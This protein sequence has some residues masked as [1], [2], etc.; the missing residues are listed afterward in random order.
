MAMVAPA[1]NALA[2][3]MAMAKVPVKVPDLALA[4]AA[5]TAAVLVARNAATVQV[6]PGKWTLTP[7][8]LVKVI[9]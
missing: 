8:M 3:A 4:T 1:Q 6:L 7:K 2:R 9:N 5:N